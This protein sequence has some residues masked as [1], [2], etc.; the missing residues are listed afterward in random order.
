MI[1]AILL[2]LVAPLIV[3]TAVFLVECG[4]GAIPA[5]RP[6]V[7]PPSTP[8]PATVVMIPAR[9]EAADLGDTL[10]R[11]RPTLPAGV[12]ILVVADN[13]DDDTA[14]IARANGAE[15][16]ERND[17]VNVGKGYA[18]DAGRRYLTD[19]PPACVVVLDADT[20]PADGAI[21]QLARSA[22]LLERPVQA[23]YIFATSGA[24]AG[25]DFSTAAFYVKNCVRQTGAHRLGAPAILTG[26]GMAF[27]W[28]VFAALPLATGHLAEDLMLGVEAALGGHAAVFA[29]TAVVRG[30]TPSGKGIATQRRRW[31]SG[32][33]ATARAYVPALLSR[34]VRDRRPAL[35]W[36]ALHLATPPFA[37]LLAMDM[38]C[39]AVL[40]L[41][42]A[43]R[44]APALLILPTLTV[45]AAATTAVAI[46]AHGQGSL[47]RGWWRLP[48][49][50]AWKVRLSIAAIRRGE[51][52]WTRTERD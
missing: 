24:S 18:L 15:A 13:C 6:R 23:S 37:L 34:A 4:L 21:E 14:G 51:D 30:E 19:S 2:I 40:V 3:L 47:L 32:F 1:V 46:L 10:A 35:A 48:H 36:L 25:A 41:A 5:G 33:T 7:A 17:L 22:T 45:L 8:M 16:I 38:V 52:R 43:V 9:N 29:A 12:R 44:P 11:C 39:S 20:I 49:Y 27:P 26:S 42:Y 28:S 50:V 31:E